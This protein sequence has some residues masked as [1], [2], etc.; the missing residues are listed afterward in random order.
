MSLWWYKR[1]TF[2][3]SINQSS[4]LFTFFHKLMLAFGF[5]TALTVYVIVS[6]DAGKAPLVE[7]TPLPSGFF[8]SSNATAEY[9]N[10][11]CLIIELL[12]PCCGR[13]KC[14]RPSV[15]RCQQLDIVSACCCYE[16]IHCVKAMFSRSFVSLG[17]LSS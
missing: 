13:P 3:V 9:F 16:L 1:S 2:R 5:E 17:A 7:K 6:S 15:P 11:I 8:T 10:G 12:F 4:V 14:S